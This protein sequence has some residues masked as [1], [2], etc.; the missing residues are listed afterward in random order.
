MRQSGR[1]VEQEHCPLPASPGTWGLLKLKVSWALSFLTR[2]VWYVMNINWRIN[3]NWKSA[4]TQSSS[5]QPINQISWSRLY[6]C[7]C[8]FMWSKG[9]KLALC[10][11]W[12]PLMNAPFARHSLIQET[13]C[14]VTFKRNMENRSRRNPC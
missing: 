5:S 4:P 7:F 14:F 13:N 9:L 8:L 11:L 3:Q 1:L 12:M 6:H 10:L 2:V